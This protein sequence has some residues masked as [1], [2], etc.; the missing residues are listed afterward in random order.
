MQPTPNG[1]LRALSLQTR[2]IF[3][4]WCWSLA[5]HCLH[6]NFTEFQ[7]SNGKKNM[8]QGG[9]E[10]ILSI[11]REFVLC[12]MHLMGFPWRWIHWISECISSPSFSVL[13]EGS[14]VGFF[15]RHRGIRQGDQLSP[16]LFVFAM[17]ALSIMLD[18]EVAW[19]SI[20]PMKSH[21][22]LSPLHLLSADNLL[23][24]CRDDNRLVDSIGRLFDNLGSFA[25]LRINKENS[26]LFCRKEC[27]SPSELSNRLNG[28]LGRFSIR[29]LGLPL[30]I[31][32][33]KA[34]DFALVYK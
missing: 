24:F 1:G 2:L 18:L 26:R 15:T 3:W 4:R 34:R 19:K 31:V 29:Y 12:I 5:T 22:F 27:A 25:G 6:M 13:I 14:P 33:P 9:P 23:V 17:E 7:W 8:P 11:N 20:K 16:Y 30:S 21:T 32:Y 28:P 10:K